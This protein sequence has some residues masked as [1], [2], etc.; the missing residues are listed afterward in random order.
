MYSPTEKLEASPCSV[1]VRFPVPSDKFLTTVSSSDWRSYYRNVPFEG[2]GQG[3]V[4][5]HR[6]EAF[7][8]GG[9]DRGLHLGHFLCLVYQ[10][11]RG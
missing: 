7:A 11:F 8:P 2:G 10:R 9:G 6:E 5:G 1:S 3:L 4:G